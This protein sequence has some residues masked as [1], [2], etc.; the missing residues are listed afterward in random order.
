MAAPRLPTRGRNEPMSQAEV[1]AEIERLSNY[2]EDA[3]ETLF[4]MG[5]DLGYAEVEF[6][7]AQAQAFLQAEGTVDAR[8]AVVEIRT[9]ALRFAYRSAE[10][11]YESQRERLR[12]VRT[13]LDALRSI[14]VNVR[15]QVS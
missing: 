12:T 8:K 14:N 11:L 4:E 3:T 7:R 9:S 6:K 5:R 1:E 13:Q 10:I 2:L 15:E